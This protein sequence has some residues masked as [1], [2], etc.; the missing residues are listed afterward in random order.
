[1]TRKLN[2]NISKLVQDFKAELKQRLELEET[3]L[4]SHP[5]FAAL[6]QFIQSINN[7]PNLKVSIT[8][9]DGTTYRIETIKEQKSKN[10]LFTDDVYRE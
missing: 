9:K 5:N 7:N 1:M 2:R 10:P 6:E 4:S 8:L 3:L